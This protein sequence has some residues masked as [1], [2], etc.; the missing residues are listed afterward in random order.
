VEKA[1]AWLE[2]ATDAAGSRAPL[3]KLREVLHAGVRLG[4]DVPQVRLPASCVLPAR[5]ALRL[6]CFS[7]LAVPP[8]PQRRGWPPC[9]KPQHQAGDI[10]YI[11]GLFGHGHMG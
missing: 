8:V 5:L 6:G 4:A 9:R 3:K 11:Q 1:E 7:N 10:E 2:R